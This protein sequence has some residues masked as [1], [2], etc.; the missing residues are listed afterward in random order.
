M[1]SLLAVLVKFIQSETFDWFTSAAGIAAL[2]L[3]L[4]LL[5]SSIL[6]EASKDS[7]PGHKGLPFNLALAPLILVLAVAGA[8]RLAHILHIL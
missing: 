2:V 1:N 5:T 6:V 8:V 3:L 7:N 4:V